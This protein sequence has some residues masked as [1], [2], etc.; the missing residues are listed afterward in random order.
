MY[1]CEYIYLPTYI[2]LEDME[3]ICLPMYLQ[4]LLIRF[5]RFA[6]ARVSEDVKKGDRDCAEHNVL[7]V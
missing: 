6:N 3:K 1:I 4:N 2:K 5:V 7:T